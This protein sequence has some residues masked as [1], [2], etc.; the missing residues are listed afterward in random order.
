M[1]AQHKRAMGRCG[2]GSQQTI[3]RVPS[4]NPSAKP[5]GR[6]RHPFVREQVWRLQ[7]IE[8]VFGS[9][10]LFGTDTRHIAQ[11]LSNP[12]RNFVSAQI[13]WG[14]TQPSDHCP[15]CGAPA[16]L[17]AP[18]NALVCNECFSIS[19]PTIP[20]D[21]EIA[22]FYA[23]YN[24]NY[25]G[26]GRASSEGG[27]LP[28]YAR[29]YLATVQGVRRAGSLID[30]GTSLSPFPGLAAKAGYQV[31][32]ADWVRPATLDAGVDF[33][34]ASLDDE[35][36][37]AAIARTFDVVTAFA[38]IEHCRFPLHAARNLAGICA[39]SGQV[40]LT[41][42]LAGT[43]FERHAAGFSGWYYPPE[44]LHIF[45]RRGMTRLFRSVGCELV[46]FERF[47]LNPLRKFARYA[48]CAAEGIAGQLLH[49]VRKPAWS[50]LR[51]Q[52]TT[53]GQEV[54]LYVFSRTS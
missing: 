18:R 16:T 50:R 41:T 46:R 34:S 1:G 45:S 48:I 52:R 6:P 43:Y 11:L 35:K 7:I 39:R 19:S 24:D 49:A 40:I 4:L 17:L 2:F 54:G 20:G 33:V 15:I 37:A 36:M 47:E 12:N 31:T 42:P 30:V 21:E 3:N 53:A 8:L 25:R 10:F 26:G 29:R 44:H 9:V 27:R 22:K 28:R 14:V 32:V 51:E 5:C 38:V 23:S 13:Y